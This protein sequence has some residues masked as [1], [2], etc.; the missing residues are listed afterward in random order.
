VADNY[1]YYIKR[2][3]QAPKIPCGCGCGEMI[4]SIGRRGYPVK[5]KNGHSSRG[6][7]HSQWKG[8]RYQHKGYWY[9]WKPEHHFAD[10][11]G[12]VLEHRLVYEQYYKCSLLPWIEIHHINEQRDDNRIENLMPVTRIEHRKQHQMDHSNTICLLCDSKETRIRPNGRPHWFRFDNGYICSRCYDK[13]YSFYQK[14]KI[15]E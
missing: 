14:N 8:G 11:K 2:Q 9:I 6:K 10:K 1:N 12:Y 3:E 5:F 13:N 4:P 7:N 15:I